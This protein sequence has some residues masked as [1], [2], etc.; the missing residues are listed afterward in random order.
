MEKD[1]MFFFVNYEGVQLVQGESKL[2]PV[3]GCN[4][5][6]ANCIITAINCAA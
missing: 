6:A 4:L 5:N 3:P 2:G 1:K